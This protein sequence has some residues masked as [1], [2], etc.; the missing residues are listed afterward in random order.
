MYHPH[1]ECSGNRNNSVERTRILRP[2][3]VRVWKEISD[4]TTVEEHRY[5]LA[6][7]DDIRGESTGHAPIIPLEFMA[8]FI[9]C[10]ATS[11]V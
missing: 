7:D 9:G 5:L 3:R 6:R 4:A 11:T 2:G 1:A 10:Y 8:S